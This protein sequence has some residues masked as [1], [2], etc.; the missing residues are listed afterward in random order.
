MGPPRERGGEG[1]DR[2]EEERGIR[3]IASMGPPRERGGEF[4]LWGWWVN[5]CYRLQWG[6]RVN[7]AERH[8]GEVMQFWHNTSRFARAS[9]GLDPDFKQE[10]AAEVPVASIASCFQR[11]GRLRAVAGEPAPLDRSRGQAMHSNAI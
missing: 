3:F 4:Q 6:R 5:H 11:A 2:Q 9:H 7:A 8:F 1:S 10:R